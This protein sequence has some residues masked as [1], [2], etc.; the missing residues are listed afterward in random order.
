MAKI[1]PCS[2]PRGDGS[3]GLPLFD[4]TKVLGSTQG[5]KVQAGESP[6]M[7]LPLGPIWGYCGATA[8][9]MAI[10]WW[11]DLGVLWY[12]PCLITQRSQVHTKV[13]GS[14]CWWAGER[15]AMSSATRPW[16]GV[17]ANSLSVGSPNVF[18][19][20]NTNSLALFTGRQKLASAQSYK[21]EH[22]LSQWTWKTLPKML[23]SNNLERLTNLTRERVPRLSCTCIFVYNSG[24]IT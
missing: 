15:S 10:R 12:D 11:P 20:T 8:V 5:P 9:D 3:V 16:L 13:L 2:N 14:T 19:N 24:L 4:I 21:R 6:A 17:I 23:H 7:N 1:V 22:A 18:Q